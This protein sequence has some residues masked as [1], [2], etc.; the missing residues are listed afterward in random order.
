MVK[1]LDERIAHFSQVYLIVSSSF[2]IWLVVDFHIPINGLVY[3]FFLKRKPQAISMGKRGF[4]P[5][6]SGGQM[7][8]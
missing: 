4:H 2:D 1:P 7:F 6:V 5:M 8:P 3:V